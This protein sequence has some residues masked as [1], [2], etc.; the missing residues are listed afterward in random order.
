MFARFSTARKPVARFFAFISLLWLAACDV[1]VAPDANTG[2]QINPTAPVQVALLVPG[3]SAQERD[4][5]IARDFENAARLAI[6]DIAGARIDLRVYNTGGGNPAQAAEAAR[7]AVDDGA[8]IIVGP[9]Y[10]EAANAAGVAVAGRN[11]NVLALS[12]NPTIAGGNV[13]LLGATFDNTANRLVQYG[14]R[15]GIN[16]YMVV[17]GNN[18]EG[19][20]GRDAITNAVQRNGAQ[21]VAIESYGLS[22]QGIFSA[23][24]QIV[25]G[26]SSSGAQAIFMTAS[27]NADLPILAT[28]L[29]DA[30]IDPQNTR[31]F[32]L[33]R[34]DTVP[35]ALSL[36]G[37]QGGV[38]AMPDQATA[39]LFN[40]RYAAA[41]GQQPHPLAGLAYDG[42]AAI[43]ALIAQGNRDALTKAA[44][45]TPEGFRGT[46]GAFR[47]L[48]NGLNE[49]ALAIATIQDNQV[50]TLEQAPRSFGAAGF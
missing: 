37:L 6:A 50:V 26:A 48:P 35:Q 46:S 32:G 41:Y 40:N 43:G 33:T 11:V 17:H 49:R 9:L 39:S 8:K 27:L 7:A 30:G 1:T 47:L 38:F 25:A 22:Q 23:T 14:A 21:V 42:I 15:Q 24:Q 18:F 45:T 10:G 4:N 20:T 34:W 36:P 13:F 16:R 19:Q 2:R 12:N 5:L 29:P 31:F 3:G 28:A 44:L